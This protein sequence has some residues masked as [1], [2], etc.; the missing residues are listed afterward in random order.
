[1]KTFR[2]LKIGDYI[3]WYDS[4]QIF[5]LKITEI[6]RSEYGTSFFGTFNPENWETSVYIDSAF[7]N[8]SLYPSVFSHV[9]TNL[10][11]LLTFLCNENI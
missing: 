11:H 7:E 2:D 5:K 9:T 4:K 8:Y 6:N 1:M 3:Y 10:N